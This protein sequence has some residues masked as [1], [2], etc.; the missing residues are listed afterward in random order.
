MQLWGSSMENEKENHKKNIKKDKNLPI[1]TEDNLDDNFKYEILKE[2]GGENFLK[3]IQC[4]T[5]TASCPVKEIDSEYNCRRII[6]FA[7]LGAKEQVLNSKFVWMCSTCYSC[8]ERCPWD[9]KITDLM[10]AFKNLAVKYGYIHPNILPRIEILRN[11][12]GL[13]EITKFTNKMREKMGLPKIKGYKDN[14]NKLFDKIKV[15]ELMEG[16]A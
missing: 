6:R 16:N 15:E 1:L 4:G 2:P 12:G 8:Y 9:V 11:N 14:I 3:C 7:T 5:C 10:T 13:F